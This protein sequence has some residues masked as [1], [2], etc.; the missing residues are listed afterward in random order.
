MPENIL[1]RKDLFKEKNGSYVLVGNK[2]TKCGRIAFPKAT[3]CVHC[4]N[5]TM[6]EFELSSKG[7]L[8]SY[9]ITRVPV[10]KFP[11]PHAI[12]II[13]LPERVRLT[14]PL[15]IGAGNFKIGT[16]MEMVITTLW[17][18]ADKNVIGYKFKAVN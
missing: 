5:E 2:C 10:D 13:M 12:G 8:Y 1:F 6:E 17:T 11:V 16:E 7:T 9:T 14:T 18:E 15:V 3:F 4:L